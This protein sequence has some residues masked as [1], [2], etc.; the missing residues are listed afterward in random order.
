[1]TTRATD[2]PALRKA[3]GA[4]F[5]PPELTGFLAGWAIRS[6]DDSVLEPSC[7]DAAFLLPAAHRLSA[8]GAPAKTLADQLQGVEIHPGSAVDAADRLHA[9]G[10]GSRIRADNFFDVPPVP[11][12]DAVIGNPPYVRYQHFSGDARAKGLQAALAQGMRLT[13]LANSWAAFTIHAAQF[14]KPDGRLGL[15]LPA[16]LLSVNYAAQV[17]RFLLRRFQAVRLVMFEEL[18]FP[19][20]LEE[21]VLL[22]AEGSGGAANF[23]VYQARTCA[24][25]NASIR[26]R[27]S[28]SHRMATP[29]GPRRFSRPPPLKFINR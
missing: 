5:T 23:E 28:V 20:V 12:F 1:V 11:V 15:V 26:P 24:I 29:N 2:T 10:F 21:V 9:A 18:V 7:G 17:R 14:L 25:S 13:G 8:L 22:L 19:D 4:F 27:G 3:R 6:A 16:E